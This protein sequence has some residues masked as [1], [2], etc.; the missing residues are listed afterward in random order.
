MERSLP[1]AV[2]RRRAFPLRR[3]TAPASRADDVT[4]A[5]ARRLRARAGPAVFAAPPPVPPRKLRR[6]S[7][8]PAVM[9]RRA[10][11][12]VR[13]NVRPVGRG[14]GGAAEAE[15]QGS[16]AASRD[17]AAAAESRRADRWVPPCCWARGGLQTAPR[18][19]GFWLRR[20]RQGGA[21][22]AR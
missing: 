11:L 14:A 10:R 20:S 7:R 2:R 8:R 6:A 22:L 3:S 17:E 18:G 9:F 15:P 19:S 5:P 12:A 4:A 16:P 13:P 21:G 1:P